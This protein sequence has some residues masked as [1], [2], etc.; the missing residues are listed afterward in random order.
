MGPSLR[1]PEKFYS[2]AIGMEIDSGIRCYEKEYGMP[3]KASD[4]AGFVRIL[5]DDNARK[6][7]FINVPK[8]FFNSKGEVLDGWG[9]PFQISVSQTGDPVVVSPTIGRVEFDVND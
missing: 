9:R 1:N 8:K 3:P 2:R 7:E 6:I 5:T 4:N